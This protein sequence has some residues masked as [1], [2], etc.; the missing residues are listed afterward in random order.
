MR[1]KKAF[2]VRGMRP[3]GK[4]NDRTHEL[5][6][7]KGMTL[8]LEGGVLAVMAK[9]DPETLTIIPLEQVE[10]MY[11]SVA[12]AFLQVV[13]GAPTKIEKGAPKAPES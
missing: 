3:P 11:P 1:I 2:L 12:E 10:Q 5:S 6:E 4:L 7:D 8:E 13:K 9:G